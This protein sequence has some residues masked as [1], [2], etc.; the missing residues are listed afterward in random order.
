MKSG[1]LFL[2]MLLACAVPSGV[3]A[4]E[5][6]GTTIES[7]VE[8]TTE[9]TIDLDTEEQPEVLADATQTA[10]ADVVSQEKEGGSADM[11]VQS[12]PFIDLLGPSLLAY[13]MLSPEQMQFKELPTNEALN[14][15]KVVGL[16]FS[17]DWWYVYL[18]RWI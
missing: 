1:I 15:K 18:V 13:E 6:A 9:E 12:G 7:A 2:C 3:L 11:P 8:E 5:T 10:E 16:Y 4:Q 14:G 17:A